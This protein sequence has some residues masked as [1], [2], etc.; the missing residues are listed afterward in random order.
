MK[1][2]QVDFL[3]SRFS[4]REKPYC[5][6]LFLLLNNSSC[7]HLTDQ[8]QTIDYGR[9]NISNVYVRMC[10]HKHMLIK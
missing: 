5:S 6:F 1:I 4:F 10:I 2:K 3:L 9:L 8:D 7:E